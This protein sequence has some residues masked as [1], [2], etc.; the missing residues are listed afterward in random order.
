E[1]SIWDSAIRRILFLGE[2]L[3]SWMSK[4]H[5]YTAMSTTK[6]KYMALSASCAQPKQSH[7]TP[8]STLV[9]STSM[10]ITTLSRNRFEYL[11]RRL[12]IRCLTP[13]ELE[14]LAIESA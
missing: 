8:C 9:P 2:K 12:G 3:V 1:P 10:S 6:G 7:A 13:A 11:V 4:K 14:V 5:G